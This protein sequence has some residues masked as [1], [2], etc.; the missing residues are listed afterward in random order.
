M[1]P[2]ITFNQPDEVDVYDW[3]GSQLKP[4]I[5]QYLT[6]GHIVRIQVNYPEQL[7]ETI[8]L[9]I[10]GDEGH[11]LIGVV[12]DTYRNFFEGEILYIENGE[13]LRFPRAC[14]CEVP[15]SW[16]PDLQTVAEKTGWGRTISGGQPTH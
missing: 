3:D 15:L 10:I 12:Q 4:A 14:V 1:H 8:Y 5:R 13:T 7:W 9:K 6:M 2:D 16:N 11:D